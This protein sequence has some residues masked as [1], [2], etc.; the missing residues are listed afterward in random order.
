[1]DALHQARRGDIGES[2]DAWQ[3]QKALAAPLE[4]IWRKPDHGIWEVRGEPQHF[5]HSKI[6]AWVAIDRAIKSAEQCNLDGPV[7][8]WRALRDEIHADIC[9]KAWNA[10]V[11]AFVQAYG[12]TLIDASLLLM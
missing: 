2:G 6:M 3:L 1:M 10:D 9:E 11:G 8:H 4:T 7:D 5:T 12:S